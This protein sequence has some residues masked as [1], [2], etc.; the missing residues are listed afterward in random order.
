MYHD[1]IQITLYKLIS[2]LVISHFDLQEFDFIKRI[3]R[4]ENLSSN[5][6]FINAAAKEWKRVS[7]EVASG[8]KILIE[9]YVR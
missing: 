8:H 7:G 5:N 1:I 3:I 9:K 4:K 2:C 6:T